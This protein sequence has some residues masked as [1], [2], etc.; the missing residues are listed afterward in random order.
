MKYVIEYVKIFRKVWNFLIQL[1]VWQ[2]NL[3][4]YNVFQ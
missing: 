4:Q 1:N 2:Y 3:M